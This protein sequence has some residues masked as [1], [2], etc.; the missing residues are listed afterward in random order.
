[1][2]QPTTRW[3]QLK[4]FL[5]SPLPGEMIQFDYYCSGGLKPPT[6]PIFYRIFLE[7]KSSGLP[8]II[9][10]YFDNSIWHP[11]RV[12]WLEEWKKNCVETW[13]TL[14]FHYCSLQDLQGNYDDEN[15]I[16]ETDKD[17]NAVE[18]PGRSD[19][20]AMVAAYSMRLR[21]HLLMVLF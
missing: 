6:R 2:L 14:F 8:S 13:R 16:R 3:W 20:D 5:F 19:D 18:R 10:P 1:M 12:R 9:C 15:E 17:E 4:Y 7:F 21:I 11:N